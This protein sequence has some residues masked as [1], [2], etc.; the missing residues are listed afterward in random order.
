MER[1]DVYLKF[2]DESSDGKNYIKWFVYKLF[3]KK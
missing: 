3:G 1:K 2:F